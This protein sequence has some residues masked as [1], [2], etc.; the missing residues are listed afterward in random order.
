MTDSAKIKRLNQIKV[1]LEKV[2]PYPWSYDEKFCLVDSFNPKISVCNTDCPGK[3]SHMV[4]NDGKFISNS[5]ESVEWLIEE[6][7]KAWGI[8]SEEFE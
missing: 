4:A 2:S 1:M 3:T 5:P 8:D 6:L 7:E